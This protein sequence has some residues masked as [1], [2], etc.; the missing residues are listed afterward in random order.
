MCASV[1][2][3]IIARE[4]FLTIALKDLDLPT[5]ISSLALVLRVQI[6]SSLA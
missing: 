5:M 2:V 1:K 6:A 4:R 3:V